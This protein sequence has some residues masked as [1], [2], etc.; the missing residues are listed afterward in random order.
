MIGWVLNNTQSSVSCLDL[1]DARARCE[2]VYTP[3]R[4]LSSIE[5]VF[6]MQYAVVFGNAITVVMA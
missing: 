1:Y 3:P 5:D 2:V 4:P 6:L